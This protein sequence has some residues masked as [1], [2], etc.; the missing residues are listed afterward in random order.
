MKRISNRKKRMVQ[1]QIFGLESEDK[2]TYYDYYYCMCALPFQLLN[3]FTLLVAV[4]S[5]YRFQNVIIKTELCIWIGFVSCKTSHFKW[6]SSLNGDIKAYHNTL[7][8]SICVSGESYALFILHIYVYNIQY[9]SDHQR[10]LWWST[11]D[12]LQLLFHGYMDF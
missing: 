1:K 6:V 8:Y 10:R 11:S 2:R 3:R 9:Y 5:R 7:C 12:S 4:Q